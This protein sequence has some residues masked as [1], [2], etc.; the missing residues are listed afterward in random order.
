[1]T[2]RIFT[3]KFSL[4]ACIVLSAGVAH[5]VCDVAFDNAPARKLMTA[6][7][8]RTFHPCPGSPHPPFPNVETEGGVP[9]CTAVIPK[10]YNYEMT[11]YEYDAD[12]GCQVRIQ[13]KLAADCAAV[14]GSDGEPLGLPSGACHVTRFGAKCKGILTG[15]SVPIDV[16]D[17]G[18]TLK[19]WV[20]A[21]IDDDVNGSMTIIDLPVTFEFDTPNDG[22]MSVFGVSAEPLQ[23]L[24]VF[25]PPCTVLQILDVQIMDPIGAP[26]AA[27]GG[28]TIP[29]VD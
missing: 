12:G 10:E 15:S 9:A 11:D 24:G 13:S 26:F 23:D 19:V 5:A 21:S 1:M 17:S 29:E 3:A 28:A 6:S 4:T 20:R 18:W 27:M 14:D 22:A 2:D 16:D 7:M 8:V 25:L